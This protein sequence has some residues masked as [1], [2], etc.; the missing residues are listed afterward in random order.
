MTYRKAIKLILLSGIL[1]L[2]FPMVAGLFAIGDRDGPKIYP[3]GYHATLYMV[4]YE[5][6]RNEKPRENFLYE[7]PWCYG[8]PRKQ[9]EI[10]DDRLKGMSQ[11][12]P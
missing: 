2:L 11:D 12:G 8:F 9:R 6:V 1:Y 7:R 3:K 5:A 4:S 10:K